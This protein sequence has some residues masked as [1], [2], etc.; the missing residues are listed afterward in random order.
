MQLM[1][2]DYPEFPVLAVPWFTLDKANVTFHQNAWEEMRLET[3]GINLGFLHMAII[4][5][6]GSD[7]QV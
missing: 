5:K 6:C 4:M 7:F 3:F 2:V 1:H